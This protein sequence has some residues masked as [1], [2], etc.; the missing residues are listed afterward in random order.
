LL[1][2]VELARKRIIRRHGRR[3]QVVLIDDQIGLQVI[4][5]GTFADAR[6]AAR[7]NRSRLDAFQRLMQLRAIV[8]EISL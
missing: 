7:G 6:R 8:G 5:A 1:I 2:I 3:L 4:D